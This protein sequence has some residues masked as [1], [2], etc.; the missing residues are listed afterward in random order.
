MYEALALP[1]FRRKISGQQ[2]R[3][4]GSGRSRTKLEKIMKEHSFIIGK[5]EKMPAFLKAVRARTDIPIV[6]GEQTKNSGS[7]DYKEAIRSQPDYQAALKRIEKLN[8]LEWEFYNSF[9]DVLM[10]EPREGE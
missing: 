9:G 4:L 7:R 10:T 6:L 5:F 3:F 8:A 1:E 2:L